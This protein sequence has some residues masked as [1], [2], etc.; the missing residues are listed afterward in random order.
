MRTLALALALSAAAQTYVYVRF[1]GVGGF[2]DAFA[3]QKTPFK[4]MVYVFILSEA[5]PILALMGCAVSLRGR[6][7]SRYRWLVFWLLMAVMLLR[8]FFGGLRG[9]RGHIIIA[10]FWAAGCLHFYVRPIPRVLVGWGLL[11]LAVFMYFYGFYKSGGAEGVARAMSSE[12]RGMLAE[13]YGRTPKT[14]LLGDFGRADLQAFL[15]FRGATVRNMPYQWGATYVAALTVAYRRP[16]WRDWPTGKVE[17]GTDALYGRGAY[18]PPSI[19]SFSQYGLAGEAL[20]NFGPAGVPAAFFVFGIV[21]GLIRTWVYGL[22]V[23]DARRLL[24]PLVIVLVCLM[25][26]YDIDVLVVSLVTM[27]ALPVTV[28][29]VGSLRTMVQSHAA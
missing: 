3:T 20:L 22:P 18:N 10:G 13:S 6:R 27:G 5:F 15:L 1:G 24:L 8:V 9:S 19:R 11:F 14:V 17:A 29:V 4:D 26:L 28:V 7:I 21:A 16:F 23:G 2:A 12:N 25:V